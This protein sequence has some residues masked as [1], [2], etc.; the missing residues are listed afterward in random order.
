[1]TEDTPIERLRRRINTLKMDMHD[2][3]GVFET[4]N[5]DLR[6]DM[7]STTVPLGV[8]L[9]EFRHE[10]RALAALL[11]DISV[12]MGK[13]EMWASMQDMERHARQQYIDAKQQAIDAKLDEIMR[14]R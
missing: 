12:R 8:D 9:Y 3:R 11:Q 13:L 6:A 2:L 4:I 1:M 14:R 7:H 5:H 10:L